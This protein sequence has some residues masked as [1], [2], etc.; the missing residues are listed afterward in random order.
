MVIGRW[1]RLGA[2]RPRLLPAAGGSLEREHG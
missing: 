2:L 1:V